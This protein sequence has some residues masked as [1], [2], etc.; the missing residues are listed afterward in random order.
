MESPDSAVDTVTESSR[1]RSHYRWVILLLMVLFFLINWADRANIGI[2]LPSI[3]KEFHLSNMQAGALAGFFFIGYAFSQIPAGLFMARIGARVITSVSMVLFSAITFLI[4]TS[5]GAVVM[6]WFRLGLGFF[7]GPASVGAGALL[8][9]WFPKKEQ[10]TATGIYLS[11]SNLAMIMVPPICAAII[12]HWGW[13]Y[14]FYFS[15]IPGVLIAIFWYILVRNRPEQSPFCNEG[16]RAYILQSDH[17]TR[18][19]KERMEKSMGWVDIVIRARRGDQALETNS[20]VMGT[21]SIWAA[22]FAFFF[23]SMVFNGM[24]TWIPSFLVKERGFS[25]SHVGWLA[26]LTPLG[27]VVGAIGGGWASDRLWRG[28]RKPMIFL[29]LIACGI[30]MYFLAQAPANTSI[31]ALLLFLAGPSVGIAMG[32]YISYPM[33]LTTRKTY[34]MAL[35]LVSTAG[36]FGGFL[37]PIIA[38]YLLDTFKVYSSVFL[39]FGITALAAFISIATALEPLGWKGT[40]A[41]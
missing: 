17:R 21:W 12:I 30:I 4:G 28:R 22:F 40:E 14:V 24:I 34:P 19:Q 39:F 10:A 18:A 16:E 27:Y 15:A 32:L 5:P 29:S 31:L 26:A 33:G 25:L 23:T 9:A 13:R 20:R 36:S 7:E 35:A 8:K 37:S 41:E 38:G 2:C 3:Q 11:S 6:N 1:R